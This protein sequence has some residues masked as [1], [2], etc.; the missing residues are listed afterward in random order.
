V[1]AAISTFVLLR[2]GE[3]RERRTVPFEGS[4]RATDALDNSTITARI[5]PT[6]DGRL[7]VVLADDRVSFVC[8]GE[9]VRLTG[10]GTVQG[11][12]L[13]VSLVGPC[14]PSG[15]TFSSTMSF[16]HHLSTDTLTDD[17]NPDTVWSRA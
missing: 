9:S 5:S 12:T 3:G 15:T 14:D 17:V 7:R 16:T 4:W 2:D 11:S 1:V 8:K 13:T 6:D 10:V